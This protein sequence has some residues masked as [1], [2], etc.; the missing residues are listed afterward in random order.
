MDSL[1]QLTLG[2]AV[3]VAVM[4]RRTAA[5]KAAAWGAVVGTLPDLDA[6]V[7]HGDAVLDMVRHRAETHALPIQTLASIPIAWLIARVHGQPFGRW[8]LA[9][10]LTLVT[11]ALLDAFT[12]YGTQPSPFTAPSCCNRSPTTPT[13]WAVCS[14]STRCTRCRC[15]W[16][17]WRP[18]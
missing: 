7:R 1:T 10:W 4:G 13:A 16:A 2:A 18:C 17:C 6:L 9:V 8:W 12:I 14:L 5:W 15:W 3:T 11:H